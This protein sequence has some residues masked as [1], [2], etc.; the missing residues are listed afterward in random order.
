MFFLFCFF[1]PFQANQYF[2]FFVAF[3]F[4]GLTDTSY[5]PITKILSI[6]IQSHSRVNFI[7][8]LRSSPVIY[9]WRLQGIQDVNIFNSFSGP[10]FEGNDFHFLLWILGSQHQEKIFGPS[11]ALFLWGLY[12]KTKID[13]TLGARCPLEY[14]L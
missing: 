10:I 12:P 13:R 2:L 14:I 8:A 3:E 7:W 11:Q 4:K 9:A 1:V 5:K 6:F